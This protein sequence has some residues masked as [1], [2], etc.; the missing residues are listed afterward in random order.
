MNLTTNLSRYT[1]PFARGFPVRLPRLLVL[2]AVALGLLS[3]RVQAAEEPEEIYL[4]IF[5]VIQ[6]ADQL[7]AQGQAEQALA[8]YQQAQTRLLS[9]QTTNLNFNPKMIAYRLSDVSAKSSALSAKLNPSAEAQTTTPGT[10]GSTP[11]GAAT[12]GPSRVKLITAGAEPRKALRLHPAAGDKQS[13]EMTM[14]MAMDMKMGEIQTPVKMPIMKMVMDVTVKSV[15]PQ[16][17]IG[18]EMVMSDASVADD[19]DVLPQVADAM[20]ASF[21]SMKG[22]TGTGVTTSRGVSK[23]A[24]IKVPAGAD[25]QMK[26]AMEQMKESF[27]RIST[28]FPEEPV[29][30][31]AKWEAKTQIKSQGITID[32]VSTYELASV[33]G[34]RI[35]AKTALTQS[36][37]N[38]KIQNPS[39]PAVK[40][41]LTKM[42]GT[43]AG[44]TTVDLGK[45]MPLASTMEMHSN[46]SMGMNMAGQKQT[47]DMKMDLNV[48]LESK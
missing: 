25:P 18:Y 44:E 5:E 9:F 23:A 41:D 26:Q 33:D 40:L 29:G 39:M 21:A 12:F 6:Q 1:A 17:D 19:P 31:G 14:K 34:E 30:L 2:I 27:S 16:G 42:T 35:N 24:D 7:S 48:S 11:S 4:R 28:A 45:I 47:M 15:S 20:K 3:L 13:L 32:Q 46:L 43:G 10:A 8:K 22:M 38:Q 37:A 36:A